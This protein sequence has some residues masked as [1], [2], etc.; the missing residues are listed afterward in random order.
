MDDDDDRDD[1]T[2]AYDPYQSDPAFEGHDDKAHAEH[3]LK[4]ELNRQQSAEDADGERQSN[5]ST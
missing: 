4:L 5:D 2:H 3:M 1:D